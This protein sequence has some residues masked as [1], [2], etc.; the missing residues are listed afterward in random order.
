MEI[1]AIWFVIIA[2]LFIGFVA[3]DG[4][5]LGVGVF[6]LFAKNNEERD[7]HVRAIGPVWDANEVWLIAAGGALF[8]AF[9]EVY[10]SLASGF[11]LALVLLL[12]A[13]IA[14]ATSIEFR[15]MIEEYPL[16]RVWDWGFG[17]GSAVAALLLGVALGNL[18]RGIPIDYDGVF[19]GSF[20]SLLNPY[21]LLIGLTLLS[22]LSLHGACF[23][24]DK[25]TG[26]LHDRLVG[27]IRPLL[28]AFLIMLL[29][30]VVASLNAA[31][32]I[33]AGSFL[34][35][36]LLLMSVGL[37]SIL[38][39]SKLA[40]RG[41]GKGAFR[42]SFIAV[43]SFAGSIASFLYPNLAFSTLNPNYSLSVFNAS[44]SVYTLEVMLCITL[45]GMPLVLVYTTVVHRLF[46]GKMDASDGHY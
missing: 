3:L 38:T 31:H 11:Y 37:G 30:S 6:H 39:V 35:F 26:A 21:A 5:D 10:A 17:L 7:L 1:Q 46:R 40:R 36:P 43:I 13:L 9:P 2:I 28:I 44:S 41:T 45:I 15:S 16:R 25:S 29:A 24:L 33:K 4:Y 14:R 20:V 23:L 12:L 34:Y 8:A 22:L 32:A 19:I 27:A 42:A 18:M